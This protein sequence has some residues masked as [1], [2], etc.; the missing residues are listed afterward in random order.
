MQSM[1]QD[2]ILTMVKP[3]HCWNLNAFLPD[4]AACTHR[5]TC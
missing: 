5:Y 3:Q 1:V 4:L 2:L